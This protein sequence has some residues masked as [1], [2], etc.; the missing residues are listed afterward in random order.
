MGCNLFFVSSQFDPWKEF[1]L[2]ISFFFTFTMFWL[3]SLFAD[4][5]LKQFYTEN[6]I[7]S[8]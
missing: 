2:F 7:Y 4:C 5:Y 1:V 6:F 3:S 8:V